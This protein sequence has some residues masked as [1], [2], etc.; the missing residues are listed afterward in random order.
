MIDYK[1]LYFFDSDTHFLTEVKNN[2]IKTD[3]KS[4]IYHWLLF[5]KRN[6][7]VTYLD[8]KSMEEGKRYFNQGTLTFL[9]SGGAFLMYGD[10]FIS[11]KSLGDNIETKKMII[12][13]LAEDLMEKINELKNG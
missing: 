9:D 2:S 8:F 7:K 11:F 12:K 6:K 13:A 4:K 1:V 10:D 3:D 5:D